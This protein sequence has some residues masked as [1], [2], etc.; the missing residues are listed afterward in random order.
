MRYF[1][2]KN[3]IKFNPDES[4]IYLCVGVLLIFIGIYF[5]YPPASLI[6]TG[7]IFSAI[8]FIEA[9]RE[10]KRGTS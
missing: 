10:A 2:F 8:S 6:V 1:K 7:I 9:Q 4:N 5:I 3:S